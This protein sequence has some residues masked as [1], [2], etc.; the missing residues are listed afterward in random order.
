MS[1]L[2]WLQT[3]KKNKIS[4]LKFKY[5]FRTALGNRVY[6]KSMLSTLANI[7]IPKG[8]FKTV[9]MPGPAQ[10]LILIDL[11]WASDIF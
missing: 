6:S 11:R 10:Y 4:H 9:G 3:R 7:R 5:T 2:R 8:A 1:F